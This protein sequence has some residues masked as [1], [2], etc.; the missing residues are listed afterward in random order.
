MTNDMKDQLNQLTYA[1]SKATIEIKDNVTK[2]LY[3]AA[4]MIERDAKLM[5][6]DN[7]Q[8]DTGRLRAS[9]TSRV[10]DSGDEFPK[11]E[12]G[13]NVKYAHDVEFGSGPHHVPIAELEEWV[14]RKGLIDTS[15]IAKGRIGKKYARGLEST[16]AYE[17]QQKIEKYGTAPHPFL[18]PAFMANRDK[19]IT[20]I[21]NSVKKDRKGIPLEC[22]K[23]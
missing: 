13:T 4:L 12:I 18:V 6:T 20:R 10:V 14:H 11:A 21:R 5:I 22:E 8:V 1:F 23:P 2:G 3:Q 19:I 9:I 16:L 7:G 15:G 17:I